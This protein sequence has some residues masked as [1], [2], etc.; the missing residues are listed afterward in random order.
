MEYIAV[1]DHNRL[2]HSLF[3]KSF[4][5]AMGQQTGCSGIILHGDSAYTDRLIQTGMMRRDAVLRS[6]RDLNHRMAALLAD[7]GVAAVAVNG[8]QKEIIRQSGTSLHANLEWF[9]GRPS[10]IHV[11][12]SNLVWDVDHSEIRV[13][14][15]RDMA[16]QLARLLKKDNLIIFSTDDK[17]LLSNSK[18][19]PQEV[20][21][22]EKWSDIRDLIPAELIPPPENCYLATA[23]AFGSLPETAQFI[24]LN[25]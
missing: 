9:E 13:A 21:R 17:K 8:Y 24:R 3:M 12:L 18:H 14:P 22:T 16:V 15:L 5:D 23:E 20:H 10:G 1:I 4:A 6:T 7:S 11:I 2:D 19:D 25:P